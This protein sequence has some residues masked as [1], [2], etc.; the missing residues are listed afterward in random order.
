M[1]R[2]ERLLVERR[3]GVVEQIVS[4]IFV[5]EVVALRAIVER[6]ALCGARGAT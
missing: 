1:K 6:A 4:P 3:Y 2:D 5:S